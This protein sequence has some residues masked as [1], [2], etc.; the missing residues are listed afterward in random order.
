MPITCQNKARFGSGYCL[1]HCGV[2]ESKAYSYVRVDTPADLPPPDPRIV[3]VAV[4]DMNHGWPN[5]GHDSLVHAVKDATCDLLADAA[6]ALSV[7]VISFD[8]RR[9]SG[10]PEGPGGRFAVYLGTGGPGHLDPRQNDGQSEFSQGIREDA[11]WEPGLYRLFDAIL[12]SDEAALLAVCHTFGVMCRWTG[13]ARPMLRTSAKA[14]R[15][16]GCSTTSSLPR[17][18]PIPGS[19]SWPISSPTAAACASWTIACS[20]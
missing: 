7:R 14:A 19:A 10:I 9:A 1:D 15:A 17:A 4:L 5:L 3:D 13:V 2:Y 8:V 6:G 11:S 18:W 16:P 12:E 20:T